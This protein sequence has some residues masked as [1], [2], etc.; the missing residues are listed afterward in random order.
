MCERRRTGIW[1]Q[2]ADAGSA[3]ERNE[4]G[5]RRVCEHKEQGDTVLDH[6][7]HGNWAVGAAGEKGSF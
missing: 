5:T 6:T 7:V 2:D 1:A 4:H 3:I